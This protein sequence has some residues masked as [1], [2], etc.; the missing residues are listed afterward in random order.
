MPLHPVDG[1]G[2]GLPVGTEAPGD[3][4]GGAVA[5]TRPRADADVFANEEL[6]RSKKLVVGQ[7]KLDAGLGLKWRTD[8]QQT[9]GR[10]EF[11]G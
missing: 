11:A 1:F 4:L 10:P 8:R 5:R 2:R 3:H 7:I 9:V 6:G